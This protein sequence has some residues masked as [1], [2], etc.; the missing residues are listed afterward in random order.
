MSKRVNL[1]QAQPGSEWNSELIVFSSRPIVP[2]LDHPL[3]LDLD[4]D[5]DDPLE[6]E[7][8]MNVRP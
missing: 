8:L 6:L 2:D 3:D 7:K 4:L 5:L 1:N